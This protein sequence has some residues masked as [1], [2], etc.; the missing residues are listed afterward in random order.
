MQKAIPKVMKYEIVE[1][2]AEPGH[3]Y[4]ESINEDGSVYVVVF[5]GPEAQKRA[6]E[7]AEWK[8]GVRHPATV[9]H[10]VQR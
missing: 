1:S 7:Y 6:A 5:S 2:S 10:L 9:L 3:W 8:N 4:V